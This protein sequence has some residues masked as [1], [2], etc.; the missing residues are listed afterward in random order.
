MVLFLLLMQIMIISNTIDFSTAVDL[1]LEYN[2]AMFSASRYVGP[3]LG[4]MLIGRKI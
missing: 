3:W 1:F 4:F 2:M